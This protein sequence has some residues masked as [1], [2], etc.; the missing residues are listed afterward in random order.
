[1]DEVLCPHEFDWSAPTAITDNEV[2]EILAQL[3][4]ESRMIATIDSCHSGDQARLVMAKGVARTLTP[5]ANMRTRGGTRN[6]FRAAGRAPNISFLSACSPWQ[7]AADTSFDGRPN[8]AFTY[9][10]VNQIKQGPLDTTLADTALAIEPALRSFEMSP[11]AENGDVP[12][13]AER[14]CTRGLV[15]KPL[16]ARAIAPTRAG[17]VLFEQSF[18]ASLFGQPLDAGVQIAVANGELTSFIRAT[19]MGQGLTLP[20]IRTTGNMTVPLPLG[21]FGLRLLF[22][23]SDWRYAS[24]SIEFVLDLS[25]TSDLP[26]VPRVH[27]ARV[28][29]HVNIGMIDRD[30]STMQVTSPA[31]LVALLTLRQLDAGNAQ[32]QPGIREGGVGRVLRDPRVQVVATG[33]E[34]WGPNWREERIV[35]PFA[36]RP[37]PDGIERVA[38][39]I[40]P[41]YGAGNVYV[42]GWHSP[43]ETDFDFQLHIGNSFWGGWGN[44]EWRAIGIYAH[45]QPFPRA[46]EREQLAPAAVVPAAEH[47]PRASFKPPTNGKPALTS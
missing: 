26:F 41:Q 43:Q 4:L 19:F 39:E 25:L 8:G 10:F 1:M 5:P 44:I 20:P 18:Q 13:F 14:T 3:K 9:H 12:Y 21:Y 28:P 23:V 31:D 33:V 38:I 47:E 36:N 40:G 30:L 46:A 29:V 45:I 35:R 7:V 27:I 22:S 37:R 17:T 15:R 6:G 2:L 24:Q 42:V 32:P 16:L 11:V 34:S